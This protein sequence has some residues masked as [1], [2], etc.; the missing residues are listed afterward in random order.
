VKEVGHVGREGRARQ[1]MLSQVRGAVDDHLR[2]ARGPA[3]RVSGSTSVWVR[4]RRL[5]RA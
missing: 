5:R 2:R 3:D 4:E 1:Q